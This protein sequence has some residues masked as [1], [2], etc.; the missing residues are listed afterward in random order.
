MAGKPALAGELCVSATR[1]ITTTDVELAHGAAKAPCAQAGRAIGISALRASLATSQSRWPTGRPATNGGLEQLVRL[2]ATRLLNEP[3][4][5]WSSNEIAI[6]VSGLSQRACAS[7]LVWRERG[8]VSEVWS[9]WLFGPFDRRT[10]E[11]LHR[12]S[13]DR[14]PCVRLAR[15]SRIEHL[16]ALRAGACR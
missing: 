6:D 11:T 3:C 1:A 14:P 4:V 13:A 2:L 15:S 9:P 16:R 12:T 7:G 8:G 10:N 5:A